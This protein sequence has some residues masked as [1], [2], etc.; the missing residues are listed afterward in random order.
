M[1]EEEVVVATRSGDLRA[2]NVGGTWVLCGIP[3][4]RPPVGDMRFRPPEPEVPWKGVR[5]AQFLGPIAPQPDPLPGMSIQGDPTSWDEDCLTL[6][7]WTPGL[8]DRR[9]PVMVWIH[10]GGFTT[11]SG[12]QVIYRGERLARRSDVVVV[13]INYRLGSLGF[14]THDQ[15]A[16]GDPGSAARGNWG[17]LDQVAALQWVR[18]SIGA[19][20]GDPGNVTI[21][22]ES[23]GGMSVA[24]LMCADLAAGLYHKAIIE[25]GPPV[26]MAFAEAAARAERI[27]GYCGVDPPMSRE[28]LLVPSAG[29]F[30]K[31]DQRLGSEVMRDGAMPLPHLPTVDGHLFGEPLPDLVTAGLEAKVPLL[32]G[33]NRDETSFFMAEQLMGD[34]LQPER[35][36]KRLARYGGERAAEILLSA[37]E[38]ARGGRGQS[39]TSAAIWTAITTDFVFRLPSLEMA[40]CHQRHA[41]VFVYRFDRLSPA[42]GG[43]LGSCHALE[44]PFVFG[45]VEEEAVQPFTGGGEEVEELSRR[46]QDSWATFARTG[47]PSCEGTGTWPTYSDDRPTMIF[48]P[49]VRAV[50][51]PGREER[52]AWDEA[53]VTIPPGLHHAGGDEDI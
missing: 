6:N 15:L 37:Y 8:D 13:T 14:L 36:M 35:L 33:T 22:G 39:T 38:K 44:V 21:F 19:L 48:G 16:V 34:V 40:R 52:L 41:P 25:S 10:G 26:S 11:G 17:L 51:D 31:A 23:A 1:A 46:M 2:R 28:G 29:D 9:R 4:A 49:D 47:D 53:G 43:V 3:Y 20:G 18:D 24:A 7:V 42:F 45:T 30:V 32:I 5:E 50:D 12:A 27:A